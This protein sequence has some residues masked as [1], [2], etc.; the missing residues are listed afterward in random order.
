MT[1]PRFQ[2]FVF[3]FIFLIIESGQAQLSVFGD[4]RIRPR[5]DIDDRTGGTGSKVSD[6]YYQYR[7]RLN[8]RFDIGQGYFFQSRLGHNGVA[9][10]FGKA[11]GGFSPDVTSDYSRDISNEGANRVSTDWMQMYLGRETETWGFA[12]GLIGLGTLTNPIFDLHY[13]PA[14][15]IDIPYFLRNTDAAYACRGWYS[16]NQGM[17]RGMAVVN[18]YHGQ[19]VEDMDGHEISNTA[20]GYTFYLAWQTTAGPFGITPFIIADLAGDS[21]TAPLTAGSE[22]TFPK[23]S[24]L[25]LSAFI[26]YTHQPAKAI[27][28]PEKIFTG[29]PGNEYYGGLIRLQAAG[30]AGPG[31]VLAFADYARLKDKIPGGTVQRNFYDLWTS[32]SFIAY[33]SEHGSFEYGPEWRMMIYENAG[34]ISRIRHKIEFNIDLK[35]K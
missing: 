3:L 13:Y 15:P 26:A 7:A 30:K 19:L 5:Y 24:G 6:L 8:L 25:T 10:Y 11:G 2:F 20:D 18:S 31:R 23:L 22:I 27:A 17:I 14:A 9:E 16:L 1:M 4:A 21:T 28:D 33:S 34:E 32:Y 35:F 12:L 29:R